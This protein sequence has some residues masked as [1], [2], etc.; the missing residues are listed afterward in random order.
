MGLPA[1]CQ[2]LRQS[3]INPASLE[4]LLLAGTIMRDVRYGAALN[5]ELFWN[6]GTGAKVR[7]DLRSEHTVAQWGS[8]EKKGAQLAMLG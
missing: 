6:G 1:A 4:S 3:Q 8:R 2:A 5:Y 7:D